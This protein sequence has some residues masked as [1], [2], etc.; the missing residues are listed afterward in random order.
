MAHAVTFRWVLGRIGALFIVAS[1][2]AG[3]AAA[4]QTVS[5]VTA[6]GA[7]YQFIV[8]S[9][10]NGQLVIYAH[11]AVPAGAPIALPNNSLELQMFAALATQ[12][13]AVAM[14]SY[15]ENGWAE[16][17]GAQTTHQLLGLFASR[18]SAPTRTYL[19]GTSLGGLIVVDLA[20]RFPDQ[21]DGALALCGIVGGAPLE[22]QYEGDG[23]VLFDYFFPGKLPGDLL[24]TPNLDFSP[25]SPTFTAVANALSI[26]LIAPGQPT[27]QFASV[28]GLPG[29]TP[30]EIVFSGITLVGDSLGFNDLLQRIHGH[31]SYDNT[32]TVYSGSADDAALNAGVE[33]FTATPAGLNYVAKYYTPTGQLRIPMLTLHTTQDPVVSFSQEQAYSATVAAAGASQFLVQQSVDRYGHCNLKPEEI[34]NSFQGLLLWVNFGITPPGGDVTVP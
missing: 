22:F 28:A 13:F 3:V 18:I 4:Q 8:P 34:L 6:N 9:P 24:H 29:S 14:S 16:K 2:L 7:L 32:A 27:L 15:A 19:A 1:L 17:N 30:D 33:R 10:W 21:Y 11:G 31:N 5:G 25:G 26:G 20:E 23:R 12:G